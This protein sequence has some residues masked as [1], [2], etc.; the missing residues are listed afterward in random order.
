MITDPHLDRRNMIVEM[1]RVDGVEDPVLDPRQP[2]EAVED[3]RGPRDAV[4]WV[5]EHTAAV[6][7]DELGLSDDEVADLAEAGVIAT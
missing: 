7:R 1:D 3:G 6:L 2:G 4:P 5:G